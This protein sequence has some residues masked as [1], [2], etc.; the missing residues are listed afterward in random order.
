MCAPELNFLNYDLP[1]FQTCPL[2]PRLRGRIKVGVGVCVKNLSASAVKLFSVL[3]RA[4]V[5][6]FRFLNHSI[7]APVSFCGT[8]TGAFAAR[9]FS[10]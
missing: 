9:V 6:Q 7:A 10:K 4:S 5:V 3:L 1:H 8:D 2:L